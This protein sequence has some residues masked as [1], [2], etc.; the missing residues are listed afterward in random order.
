LRPV[1]EEQQVALAVLA[2]GQDV[3]LGAF[4][5]DLRARWACERVLAVDGKD[6]GQELG[7]LQFADQLRANAIL[8][9]VEDAVAGSSW[10]HG[11]LK[12]LACPLTST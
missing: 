2:R 12:R 3:E 9:D 11:D 4:R 7:M 10:E 1:G 5:E 8:G 6:G